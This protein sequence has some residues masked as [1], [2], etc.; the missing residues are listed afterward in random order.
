VSHLSEEELVLHHYGEAE[1]PRAIEA[2]LA[3]CEACRASH[4]ALVRDLSAVPSDIV[5]ERDEAYG[6]RV[7]AR[8]EPKLAAR[9][10]RWTVRRMA[11]PAALAA[12]L[13]LAFLLGRLTGPPAG[14]PVAREIV[15]ERILLVAVGEHLDRSRMVLVELSH[16]GEKGKPVDISSEQ[17]W[18]ASLVASNRLYRQTAVQFGDARVATVLDEL[19]RFLVEVANGPAELSPAELQVMRERIE[20]R[21]LLFRVKV[22]GSQVRDRQRD[23]GSARPKTAS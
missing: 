12:S 8:L 1:D 15:R 19:E 16:A 11:L 22:L 18:A 7:W 13:A 10:R 4:E 2:H 21:G 23:G 20:A 5:P 3:D 14:P 9:P 17:K 6:A